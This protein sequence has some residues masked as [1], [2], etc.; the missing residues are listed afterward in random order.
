MTTIFVDLPADSSDLATLHGYEVQVSVLEA[1]GGPLDA[2]VQ[3]APVDPWRAPPELNLGY[4]AASSRS[5]PA[6]RRAAMVDV[7]RRHEPA[8]RFGDPFPSSSLMF[9][10]ASVP[11]LCFALVWLIAR[12]PA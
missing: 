10:L 9:S 4:A 11:F 7:A 3:A 12:L 6:P 1:L 5:E 8:R 2:P